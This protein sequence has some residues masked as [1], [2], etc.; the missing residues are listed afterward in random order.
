MY[1]FLLAN[2]I[3]TDNILFPFSDEE[4]ITIQPGES[5]TIAAKAVTGSPSWVTASINIREDQ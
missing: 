5:I 2:K 1:Q 4:A 3:S